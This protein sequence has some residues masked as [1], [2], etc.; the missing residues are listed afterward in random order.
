MEFHTFLQQF[1]NAWS[2]SSLD[3]L[4]EMI[5]HTYQAREITPNGEISDFGY[6]ES[7]E[8]WKQGFQFVQESKSEWMLEILST[9]PLREDESMAIISASIKVDGKPMETANIFFDTFRHSDGEWKLVRSYVEAGVKMDQ[10]QNMF[11][12]FNPMS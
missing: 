6:E 3:E 1:L 4:S 11:S 12:K 7:I 9:L 2:R 5:S 10:N 8:G